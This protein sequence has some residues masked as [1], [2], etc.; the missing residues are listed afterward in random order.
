MVSYR[1]IYM[2][3]NKE[4][5]NRGAHMVRRNF[6]RGLIFLLV[7]LLAL[8][9]PSV[10][11]AAKVKKEKATVDKVGVYEWLQVSSK[12]SNELAPSLAVW[13]LKHI[14]VE[15]NYQS[16]LVV[17]VVAYGGAPRG[18]TQSGDFIRFV[19]D[20]DNDGIADQAFSTE[21]S[22]F[23]PPV[24][25]SR[26]VTDPSVIELGR[27]Y[28]HVYTAA[29]GI[30]DLNHLTEVGNRVVTA[31]Q[32]RFRGGNKWERCGF[33]M[34]N[35]IGIRVESWNRGTLVDKI[36]DS[37]NFVLFSSDYYKGLK[38]NRQNLGV[39]RVNLPYAKKKYSYCVERNGRWVW[40]DTKPKPVVPI[41]PGPPSKSPKK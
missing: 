23:T 30:P 4:L 32:Y 15:L 22:D 16:R 7:S 25:G 20:F 38:C 27:D 33:D 10:A 24:N 39:Q 31:G 9:S 21:G 41:V 11:T 6:T 37:G 28:C 19:M 12:D 34:K 26:F 8:G 13:D 40:Q 2:L 14:V 3:P 18:R 35:T 5:F 1:F 17:Y 36:P 29:Y